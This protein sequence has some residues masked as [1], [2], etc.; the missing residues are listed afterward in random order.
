[1][2]TKMVKENTSQMDFGRQ[3]HRMWGLKVKLFLTKV[4]LET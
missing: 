4:L 3:V 2:F 1:M